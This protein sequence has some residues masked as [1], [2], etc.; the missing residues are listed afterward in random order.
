MM[1]INR[2]LAWAA[3][4]A[5]TLLGLWAKLPRLKRAEGVATGVI[6]LW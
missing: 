5:E 4:V 6:G 1:R 2:F 3:N